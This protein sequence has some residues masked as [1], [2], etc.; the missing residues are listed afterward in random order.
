MNHLIYGK[1]STERIVSIEPGDET[2]VLF[3]E[4]EDGAVNQKVVPNTHYILF[5]D[6]HSPKFKRLGGDQPYRWLYETNTR[7]KWAEVLSSS[8]K[9]RY[10]FHVIR[11]PKEALMVKDGYTYFKGM[12]AS[13]VSVLSFDIE[14]NGLTVDQHSRVLLISATFRHGG[15]IERRLFSE[16][17]YGS[18]KELV[19]A[20]AKWVREVNPS[21]LLG[22]NI[23]GFDLPYLAHCAGIDSLKL[24]RDGSVVRFSDRTSQFRK[25]GSQT[26]DYVNALVYGREVIDTMFLAMK[27]DIA[28]NYESYGLKAI[29]KH[30]GLERTGRD[31]YDASKIRDNWSDPVER[32]KIK[33]YAID[34]AD[35]AL[36]LFDLMIPSFFYYTQS[37]P[38]SLQSVVNS[39]T[40]SQIN[41]LMIRAYL[42]A[43]HSIAKGCPSVEY[44]GAISFAVPG[45][46]KNVLRFDV[47]SLYPSVIRQYKVYPKDKDPGGL[48]IKM[49]DYFTEERLKNKKLGK[50]TGDRY[51]KDLEQSQKIAINSMYGFLGA[52]KLNYNHPEGAAEVT[53]H[54]RRILQAAI[55][56]ISGKEYEPDKEAG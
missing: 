20:W 1:D 2:A 56:Y 9:K 15:N 53:R 30:E 32:E 44:E 36:K 34:D 13:E 26:Y 16:D 41:S 5:A 7:Q 24:G 40:G 52:P 45:I 6:Q 21:V 54:G 3:I 14:T 8:Y 18:Q 12:K 29:V 11:D 23:F 38:R 17:E 37:V 55:K 46:H 19:S 27:F 51:F 25:D 10:D 28:R 50:E 43:G 31:H 22:H 42:Q 33:R 4:S 39:A 47:A 35:D 49:V 48:F